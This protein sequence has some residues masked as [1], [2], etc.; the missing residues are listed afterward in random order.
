MSSHVVGIFSEFEQMSIFQQGHLFHPIYHW[1]LRLLIYQRTSPSCPLPSSMAALIWVIFASFRSKTSLNFEASIPLL[2]VRIWTYGAVPPPISTA[3]LPGVPVR[4][5]IARSSALINVCSPCFSN[6]S[7]GRLPS[8]Q[9]R[10]G[11]GYF[12]VLLFI[13]YKYIGDLYITREAGLSVVSICCSSMGYPPIYP[14][15]RFSYSSYLLSQINTG[16]ICGR[17]CGLSN[18]QRMS[19][20]KNI[21]QRRWAIGFQLAA[22]LQSR[23][24][25]PRSTIQYPACFFLV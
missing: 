9:S 21:F 8:D 10:I 22:K 14:A 18:A 11:I 24:I 16:F 15:V 12:A 13:V 3:L 4:I 1:L 7:L 20:A 2:N 6:F 17:E 19:S 25:I 23:H 5:K